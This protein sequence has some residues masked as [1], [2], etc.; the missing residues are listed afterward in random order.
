M[1]IADGMT[2]CIAVTVSYFAVYP[3]GRRCS[4]TRESVERNADAWAEETPR[5]TIET[6][7]VQHLVPVYGKMNFIPV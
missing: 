1:K 7:V 4:V 5:V 6:D 3:D 2:P